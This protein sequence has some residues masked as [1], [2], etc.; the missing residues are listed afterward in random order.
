MDFNHA[1]RQHLPQRS[2]PGVVMPW[3]RRGG[4]TVR[5]GMCSTLTALILLPQ[6]IAGI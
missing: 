6:V 2:V 5:S 1:Y 3:H 4:H